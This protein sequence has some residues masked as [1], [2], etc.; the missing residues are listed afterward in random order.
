MSLKGRFNIAEEEDE[1][2][3][4]TKMENCEYIAHLLAVCYTLNYCGLFMPSLQSFFN[5]T[6]P[7]N[8]PSIPPSMPNSLLRVHYTTGSSSSCS[9]PHNAS[10]SVDVAE[11][12]ASALS[13]KELI[14][15]LDIDVDL[16]DDEAK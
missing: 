9:L 13:K 15:A 6:F 12:N 5:A 16:C 4:W 7:A 8:I 14:S 3:S 2:I 10:A 1:D 11:V